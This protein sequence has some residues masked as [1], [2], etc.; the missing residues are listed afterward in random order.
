REA[1][2]LFELAGFSTAEVRDIQ[3]GT[4]VA[5]RVRL[6][7]G[8]KRL[9]TMMGVEAPAPDTI[10]HGGSIDHMEAPVLATIQTEL[11]TEIGIHR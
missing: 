7:R 1:V 10:A 8:R 4:L 2:L 9:A 11:G 3:G 6:A 5:V